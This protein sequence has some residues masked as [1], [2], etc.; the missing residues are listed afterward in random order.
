VEV[1][2]TLVTR[3]WDRFMLLQIWR[4]GVQT[5]LPLFLNKFELPLAHR[6]EPKFHTHK[7][8]KRCVKL[9]YVLIVRIFEFG[10]RR[11]Q[12]TEW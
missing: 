3:W 10:F 2:T 4:L 5:K 8:K 12:I 6:V 11:Q 9:S 1:V 7:K